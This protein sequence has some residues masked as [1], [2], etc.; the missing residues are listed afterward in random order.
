MRSPSTSTL[1]GAKSPWVTTAT[2]SNA[3]AAAASSSA[4]PPRPRP[5]LGD[6]RCGKAKIEL[7]P[8]AFAGRVD[9]HG[10]LAA[11]AQRLLGQHRAAPALG[12]A[13]D[14]RRGL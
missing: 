7:L 11:P 14:D 13:E 9:S 4:R 2:R 5:A 8:L 1:C 6:E 3:V 10:P 12:V